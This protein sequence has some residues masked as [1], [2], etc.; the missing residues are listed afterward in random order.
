MCHFRYEQK[1]SFCNEPTC[2]A[3]PNSSFTAVIEYWTNKKQ[4]TFKLIKHRD[5]ITGIPLSPQ[6]TNKIYFTSILQLP[7]L[8][9]NLKTTAR[10]HEKKNQLI[11]GWNSISSNCKLI[12]FIRHPYVKG[13]L[14][15][16]D[17][18]ATLT[19]FRMPTNIYSRWGNGVPGRRSICHSHIP[20]HIRSWQGH[21]PLLHIVHTLVKK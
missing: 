13:F 11:P 17:D 4:K 1:Q 10:W 3:N 18:S 14:D 2:W 16:H 7:Y 6:H 19:L 9:W 8:L 20:K 12:S 15:L 21:I 5:P